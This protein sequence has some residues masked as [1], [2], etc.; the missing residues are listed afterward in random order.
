MHCLSEEFHILEIV[1]WRNCEVHFLFDL[2][3]NLPYNNRYLESQV[4]ADTFFSFIVK[5]RF[6]IGIINVM[7]C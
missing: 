6:K 1:H 3:Q 2:A 5:F 7:V 4:I